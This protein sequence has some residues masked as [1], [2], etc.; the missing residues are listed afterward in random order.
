MS[1]LIWVAV[2]AMLSAAAT[3]G[4]MAWRMARSARARESAR[5]E[6]LRSLSLG[7]ATTPAMGRS[8][9][10][11][12]AGFPSEP[13]IADVVLRDADAGPT[14]IF[15]ERAEPA[16][17]L[18]R[19]VSLSAVGAAMAAIVTLYVSVAGGAPAA[20]A[21]ADMP[22]E[23]IALDQQY[24]ATGFSVSGVVRIPA[25]R[26]GLRD[27]TAVVN[28]FDANDRLLTSRT[29]P[30]ERAA[31]E[32]GRTS[33]FSLTF[34][35]VP[36]SIARYRVGFRASGRDTVAHVDRRSPAPG[37]KAPTS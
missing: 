3:M 26:P 15:A 6:L 25:G 29:A 12:M 10:D 18:P 1:L 11:W 23:L 28:L 9:S 24:D 2:L 27:L 14:P 33:A 21:E 37:V 19:W 5:V 34:P 16:T 36:G 7:H 30:V 20:R 31:L 35:R 13:A 17:P 32:T 4:A 22:I 8:S